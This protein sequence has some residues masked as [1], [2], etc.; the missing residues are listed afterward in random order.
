MNKS[1]FNRV[2]IHLLAS[3]LF[4]MV[5]EHELNDYKNSKSCSK[6]YLT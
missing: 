6:T 1:L 4:D 2:P 5:Q 3:S